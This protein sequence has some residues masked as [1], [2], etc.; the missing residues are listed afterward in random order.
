MPSPTTTPIQWSI[1]T[2]SLGNL[3]IPG[4]RLEID[5]FLRTALPGLQ[6]LAENGWIDTGAP[7][8]VIPFHVHHGRLNWKPIPGPQLMWT[9]QI[10]DLGTIDVWLPLQETSAL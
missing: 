9:G 1:Q 3:T 2:V 8:S 6:V 5:L 4:A 7:L 10:C